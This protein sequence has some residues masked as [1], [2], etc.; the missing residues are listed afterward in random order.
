MLPQDDDVWNY[1]M[2]GSIAS[3]VGIAVAWSVSHIPRLITSR[4][5]PDDAAGKWDHRR[6]Y[7]K[8]LASKSPLRADD[9]LGSK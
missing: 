7:G 6:G 3:A 1:G 5:E 4:V 2:R 8:A 9:V